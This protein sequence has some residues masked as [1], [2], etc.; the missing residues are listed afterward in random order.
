MAI[1]SCI[2]ICFFFFVYIGKGQGFSFHIEVSSRSK[3]QFKQ[4]LFINTSIFNMK[5]TWNIFDINSRKMKIEQM[6]HITSAHLDEI[7][8]SR[9]SYC[10]SYLYHCSDLITA[11]IADR[12]RLLWAKQIFAFNTITFTIRAIHNVYLSG[13]FSDKTFSHL[14]YIRT[15]LHLQ[16]RTN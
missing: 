12:R 3:K 8:C 9:A 6:L 15:T 16:R 14:M 1:I 7:Q 5:Y 13:C 4:T 2:P 10:H 11:R